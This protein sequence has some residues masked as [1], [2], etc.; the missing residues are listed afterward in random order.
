MN[1]CC[2]LQQNTNCYN[3]LGQNQDYRVLSVLNYGAFIADIIGHYYIGSEYHEFQYD[4]LVVLQ[5][6][7]LNLPLNATNIHLKVQ[8]E[9]PFRGEYTLFTKDYAKA[10]DNC[11]LLWG[12]SFAA[13]YK[14]IPCTSPGMLKEILP[15]GAIVPY[16]D[17]LNGC[18]CRG[19]NSCTN[20]CINPY[21][22]SYFNPCF[23][24]CNIQ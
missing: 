14:Q 20:P 6:F 21:S 24:P 3:T 15:R 22:N 17:C 23:N 19:T 8:I 11:F 7:R 16:D 9:D 2:S 18:C 10:D 4:Y 5:E 1:S 13:Q 12:L